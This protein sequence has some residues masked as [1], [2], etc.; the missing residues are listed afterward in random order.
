[1]LRGTRQ[2]TE[3]ERKV[4]FGALLSLFRRRR[5]AARDEPTVILPALIKGK[6]ESAGDFRDL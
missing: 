3:A 5:R 4:G 2:P 1:V 6:K